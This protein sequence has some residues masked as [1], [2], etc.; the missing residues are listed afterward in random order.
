MRAPLVSVIIPVFNRP[1]LLR[2]A[3]ASVLA[4]T[5]RPVEIIIVD[6]G[7]TDETAGVIAALCEKHPE[8][9]RKISQSNQGPGP[10][11]N[12]G[13]AVAKG[14]YIQYLDSDDLMEPEKLRCQVEQLERMPAAG[15]S[16]CTTMRPYCSQPDRPWRR[17]GEDIG[18]IL[19]SFLAERAW[20]TLSV[21]WRRQTCDRVG[22]WSDF[23][24]LEDWEYDCRAG[25][26][27]IKPVHCPRPLAIV[28]DHDHE[29]QG[30]MK[31]RHRMS[32]AV[33]AVA[34]NGRLARVDTGCCKVDFRLA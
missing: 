14:Q 27:G 22:K 21:L 7:S 9:T 18:E 25:I 17:T 5:H 31:S 8:H 30:G 1:Q 20:S 12:A 4:Q 13:L 32:F 15:L 34:R 19:P 28:R 23:R 6:D 2:E 10:A 33:G 26:L 24:V 29:R 3:Y 16:Y 11:R